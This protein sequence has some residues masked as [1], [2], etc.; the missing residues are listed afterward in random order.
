M[1]FSKF[2]SLFKISTR[3]RSAISRAASASILQKSS[4][5]CTSGSSLWLIIFTIELMRSLVPL[6]FHLGINR[7]YCALFAFNDSR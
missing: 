5:F 7:I 6:V 3:L 1:R 4:E 2:S